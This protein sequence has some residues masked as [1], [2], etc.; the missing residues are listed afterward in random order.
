VDS[1]V[2]KKIIDELKETLP[3][4]LVSKIY[5]PGKREIL[6]E[7]WKPGG[8][9]RLFISAHPLFCSVHITEHELENPPVPPRFCQ[10]LRKHLSG[11]RIRD[12]ELTELERSFTISFAAKGANHEAQQFSLVAELFGRHANVILLDGSST[13]INALNIVTK[14]ETGVREVA[15]GILYRPLPPLPKTFLP[16]IT[17][18]TCRQILTDSWDDTPSAIQ[19]NVHG[20]SKDVV[21]QIDLS[22][23]PNAEALLAAFEELIRTY[24]EGKF[25]VG[26][27]REKEGKITLLPVISEEA[28]SANLEYYD[29]A[30]EAA[31]TYFH[32]SYV[33]EQ[34]FTLKN[35]LLTV[36]RKRKKREEKKKKR[37]EE[38]IA[39]LETLH[40][41]GR[42]GELLKQCLHTIKKGQ[43]ECSA[44]DYSQTP[45]G[46][47]LIELDPSLSPV[48]NMNRY[49][50][51]YKKGQRGVAM[52]TRFLP[53]IGEEI[54]YLDSM[55]YY[56]DE[57]KKIDELKQLEREMTE[58]GFM[59]RRARK[60]KKRVKKLKK[61][62]P[63]VHVEKKSIKDFTVYIGKNNRGN[64]HI[65][66][67]IAAPGDIWLHARHY[68]G[69]HVLIKKPKKGDMPDDLIHLLG[70]EAA[71]RS[72]GAPGG[73]VEVF[74]ADAK[75]VRKIPGQKPGMVRIRRYRTI[76]VE[77][78]NNSS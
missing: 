11:T 60:E 66:K 10:A 65:V 71:S 18:D 61:E 64:D 56:V 69:S 52:K 15:S 41:L 63:G 49:F 2:L 39:K 3:G 21:S 20:I 25:R 42:K 33:R 74:V 31:D 77:T 30:T 5:Q 37:V 78:E 38:D 72:G 35:R 12:I 44:L 32:F 14:N 62:S 36:V 75:D 51:L 16:N 67:N 19:R 23:E 43:R 48:E 55:Q 45:P 13:I 27:R 29:S 34:F 46:Q 28:G 76:M 22:K 70:R 47:V 1:F 40:D 8:G 26:I 53:K 73:K 17:M 4:S 54:G 6:F 50:R 24:R 59:R 58:L 57:A 68:P 9:H 7:L